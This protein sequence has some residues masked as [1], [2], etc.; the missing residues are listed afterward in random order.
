L[1]ISAVWYE[2]G[3]DLYAAAR[4]RVLPSKSVAAIHPIFRTPYV[5]V[6]IYSALGFIFASVG[7]FRQLAYS[8]SASYLIIYLGV[9]PVIIRFRIS[10]QRKKIIRKIPEDTD[11]VVFSRGYNMDIIKSSGE[12]N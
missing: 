5:A 4:D 10:G 12:M 7:E 1:A 11:T 6:I 8:P 9:Y 3:E 2:Y